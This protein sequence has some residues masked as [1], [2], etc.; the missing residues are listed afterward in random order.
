MYPYNGTSG[1]HGG[2]DFHAPVGTPTK[3]GLEGVYIGSGAGVTRDA[4]KPSNVVV[5]VGNQYVVYGHI[6]PK[7]HISGW[8]AVEARYSRRNSR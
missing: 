2:L 3:T 8:S 4:S 6:V 7:S 1:L 5:R